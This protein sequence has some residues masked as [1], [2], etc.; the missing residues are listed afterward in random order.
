MGNFWDKPRDKKEYIVQNGKMRNIIHGMKIQLDKY[1]RTEKDLRNE[2]SI[3]RKN[4]EEHE[5]EKQKKR[6][7]KAKQDFETN[8]DK[9]VDNWFE[10]NR[11]IDIGVIANIPIIGEIDVLPD[12]VEKYLYRKLLGVMFAALREVDI[13]LMGNKMTLD[14]K[15][16]E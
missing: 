1:E 14:I 13:S 10:K 2:I 9:F 16:D 5:V 7:C 8:L 11:E 15:P 6:E 3:L 12:K 4:F